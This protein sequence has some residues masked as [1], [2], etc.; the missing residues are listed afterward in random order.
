MLLARPMTIADVPALQLQPFQADF[1]AELTANYASGLLDAGPCYAAEVDGSVIACIGLIAFTA[2]RAEAWA[3][4]GTNAAPHMR[5]LTFAVAEWLHAT[6]F[7]RVSIAV[8]P[9]FRAAARWAEM[10]GFAR[11]G[12]MRRYFDDGRDAFLYARV[13]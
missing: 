12:I 7:Q 4:L 1:Q 13:R 11:E 3:L 10:L 2:A 9:G 8:D 6:S 5:S